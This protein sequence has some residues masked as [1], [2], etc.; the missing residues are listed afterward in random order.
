[1]TFAGFFESY[2]KGQ[3]HF[4]DL[5]FEESEDFAHKDLSN[6]IFEKCF[7]HSSNFNG[8]NLS[9]SQFIAC[10]LKCT[11]FRNA[12]LSNALI[13]NCSVESSFFKDTI[14]E[15]FRFEENW[16]YGAVVGQDALEEYFANEG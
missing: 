5:D 4:I 14:T 8:S 15:N 11:D 7:F 12:D 16:C 2:M 6:I 9:N 10:N 13:K 3:H 1:M